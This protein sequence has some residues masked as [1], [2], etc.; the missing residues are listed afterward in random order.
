MSI[1]R[2]ISGGNTGVDECALTAAACCGLQTGGFAPKD[3]MT[4]TGPNPDLSVTYN[5][6]ALDTT[7]YTTRTFRNVAA[8]DACVIFDATVLPQSSPGTICVLNALQGLK[9]SGRDIPYLLLRCVKDQHDKWV[10]APHA[11]QYPD[12]LAWLRKVD[13]ETLMV[14]GNRASK[15]PGLGSFVGNLLMQTFTELK[16]PEDTPDAPPP[17]S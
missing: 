6:T 14:G 5:L 8:A 16:V 11:W 3:F 15:A 9:D 17:V 4:E 7:D 1:S 12:V 2:V 10:L 13:P